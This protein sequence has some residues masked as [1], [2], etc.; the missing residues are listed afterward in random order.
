MGWLVRK[1]GLSVDKVISYDV[2][3]TDGNMFHA[4]KEEN[5]DLF[6]AISGGGAN[7]GVVI[8][9]EVKLFPVDRVYAGSLIYPREA[10]REIFTFYRE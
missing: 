8:A 2:V 9:M 10:A 6:W 1:Y 3:T 7:F 5:K 4:S